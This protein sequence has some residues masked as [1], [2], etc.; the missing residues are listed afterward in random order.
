MSVESI[1][2]YQPFFDNGPAFK[3]IVEHWAKARID[4]PMQILARF[5]DAAKQLITLGS[6]LQ[7]LYVAVFT[8]GSIGS[9]KQQV[10]VWMM[11]LLFTPLIL[12]ILCA[13][14]AI[15]VMPLKKEA[16]DTYD[17]FKN[18]AGISERELTRAVDQWCQSVDGIAEKKLW[19]LRGAKLFLVI[20]S[21]TALMLLLKFMRM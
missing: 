7:G 16:F 4:V 18:G 11:L 13:A 8:F 6:L 20:N 17:L 14:Q 9:T 1:Q 3:T 21:V 19:W 15:C 5:D 12:L 10:P 2:D